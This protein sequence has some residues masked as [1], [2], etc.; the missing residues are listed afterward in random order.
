MRMHDLR[1]FMSWIYAISSLL[2]LWTAFWFI[3]HII[4]RHYVFSPLRSLLVIAVFPTLATIYGVA[5]WAV[6]KG[7][8]S[9]KGWGIA[10][11]LSYILISLQL[12]IF[13]TR[14]VWSCSGVMLVVGIVGLG[15]FLRRDEQ[16]HDSGKNTAESADYELGGPSF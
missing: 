10:A 14:S 5:W 7:K 4:H 13:F 8:T 3:P 9:A 16:Q 12:I 15:A 1:K 11:S 2:A 6:W